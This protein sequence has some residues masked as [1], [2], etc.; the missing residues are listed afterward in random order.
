MFKLPAPAKINLHLRITGLTEQGYHLLD[1]S[2]V[3]VD[4]CDTLH[5]DTASDLHVSC[6]DASLNGEHNLVFRVLQALRSE[7]NVAQGLHVYVEKYLPAQ[8]GL[9]GGSSDAATALLA[10]NR[11]WGLHLT[12]SELAAFATPF[13]ADI[14]CFL[15]GRA[16][17]AAGIGERLTALSLHHDLPHIVLAH[18]GVGL[19]TKEVFTRF[20]NAHGLLPGQLTPQGV[21][22]NMRAGLKGSAERLCGTQLPVGENDLEAVSALMCPDMAQMLTAMRREQE[23]SWMSGS[24]TACV[25]LCESSTQSEKLAERLAAEQ[26]AAWTHTGKLLDCHPLTHSDMRLADWKRPTGA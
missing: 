14:P 10:A 16:S 17:M 18:P 5:I 7:Y 8:A 9:G 15:F 4:A 6:S 19:S 24:G 2:F 20:D 13:G 11:L 3:Y 12:G 26:L 25:A 1:T 21:K 22:A 23:T